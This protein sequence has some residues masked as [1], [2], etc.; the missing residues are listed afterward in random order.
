MVG[1][2]C[3]VIGVLVACLTFAWG[4]GF[5]SADRPPTVVADATLA[6]GDSIVFEHPTPLVGYAGEYVGGESH[7]LGDD[8]VLPPAA[9]RGQVVP[10]HPSSVAAPLMCAA[11]RI[12]V[13][14]G[15]ADDPNVVYFKATFDQI[16]TPE[17]QLTSGASLVVPPANGLDVLVWDSATHYLGQND[18]RTFQIGTGNPKDR[19]PGGKT[20]A[21]PEIGSFNVK[22]RA[23]DIVVMATS[24]V[25]RGFSLAVRLSDE[26]FA[27]A[28][29]GSIEFLPGREAAGEQ[30]RVVDPA[31]PLASPTVVDTPVPDDADLGG[32]GLAITND[33]PDLRLAMRP[34]SRL[35]GFGPPPTGV[36]LLLGLVVGPALVAGLGVVAF[37]KRYSMVTTGRPSPSN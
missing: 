1:R 19:S 27:P 28:V 31:R 24:G 29:D 14:T 34:Q 3:G 16:A 22:Q 25:N 30:P 20:S 36:K 33:Y 32:V 13:A 10:R 18:P 35:V 9:C 8:W 12:V 2:V 7:V 15:P 11:Y 21:S 26:K 37:W 4:E 17:I 23:Y 6:P 5:A